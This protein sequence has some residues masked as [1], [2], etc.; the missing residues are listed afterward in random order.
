MPAPAVESTD[1]SAVLSA[2]DTTRDAAFAD[3]DGSALDDVYLPG[4]AA[5]AAD[6]LTLDRLVAAGQRAQGLQLRLL[7]VQAPLATFG[8]PAN[9]VTLAV[10]RRRSR[11]C[12]TW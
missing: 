5:L 10:S 4:S 12:G 7:S 9:V 8:S 1:W 2:L 11:A 6:R 3:G